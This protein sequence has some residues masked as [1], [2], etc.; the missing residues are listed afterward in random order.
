MMRP[1]AIAHLPLARAG[2]T[3]PWPTN[4]CVEAATD[5]GSIRGEE[6]KKHRLHTIVYIGLCVSYLVTNN[7]SSKSKYGGIGGVRVQSGVEGAV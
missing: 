1:L 7:I 6:K 5:A 4:D 3:W 2:T